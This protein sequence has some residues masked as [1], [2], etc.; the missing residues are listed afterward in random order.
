M[1]REP[2]QKLLICTQ[3]MDQTSSTLGFM[4]TWVRD[5]SR[6][7]EHVTVICLYKGEVELPSNVKV[8][9]LGKEHAINSNSFLSTLTKRFGYIKK[10]YTACWSNRNEYESV[11]VHMNQE[12]ILLFGLVWRLMGKR[13]YMWRNHYDGNI[14]T[15]IASYMCKKVFYTSRY[16]YTSR[17]KNSL[18]MPVGVEIKNEIEANQNR[19]TNS[20]LFL[21]RFDPSKKPDLILK[22]IE[23]IRD[24]GYIVT[25]NF[26]GG[27]SPA[28]PKFFEEMQK[29]KTKL[30]LDSAVTF[31]GPVPSTETFRYYQTHD[32]YVNASRSGMFDKTIFEALAGG[33]LP[34]VTSK[35]WAEIVGTEFIAHENDQKSLSEKLIQALELSVEARREKVAELQRKVF[36]RHSLVTLI[37]KIKQE[38]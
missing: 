26:V 22:A 37:E 30:Q 5:L 36:P 24:K 4:H 21:S 20:I 6:V 11:F 15:K 3:V 9:S 16:S 13:V 34:I 25:A 1:E 8:I 31:V 38:V 7:Y 32:I 14:L 10:F 33:C 35:D 17:F 29:L 19:V 2:T 23:E 27:T 12:Y 28:F 18:Q